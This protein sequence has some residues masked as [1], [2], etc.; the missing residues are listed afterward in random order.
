LDPNVSLNMKAD[1]SGAPDGSVSSSSPVEELSPV[2]TWT[3][4]L[5]GTDSTSLSTEEMVGEFDGD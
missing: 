4:G 3:L 2:E 1:T 5:T